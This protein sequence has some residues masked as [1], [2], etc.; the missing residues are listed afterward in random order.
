MTL[1]VDLSPSQES[2]L[3]AAAEEQGLTPQQLLQRL[4]DRELAAANEAPADNDSAPSLAARIR[5]L[6][7]DMP[8]NVR[9]EFPEEGPHQIDRQVYGLPKR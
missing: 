8:A 5:S 3:E 2:A 4:L 6:W 7:S 9:A 1:T